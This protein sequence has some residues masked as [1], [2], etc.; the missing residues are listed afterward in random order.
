MRRAQLLSLLLTA[1]S[2]APALAQ[3]W[4]TEVQAGRIRSALDPASA[5]FESVMFGVRYDHI[6]S[7]V[8]IS[9]GVPTAADRP[10]WGALSGTH[11]LAYRRHGFVA[12]ADFAGSAFGMRGREQRT[13]QVGNGPLQPPQVVTTPGASGYAGMLQGLPLI[14]YEATRVQI[15]VR[16][17]IS[18]YSSEIGDVRRDRTVKLADVQLT[19]A[20]ASS[21]ML[22]PTIRHVIAED[23][24][25]TYAGALA[26][27]GAGP[28]SIWGSAGTWA[29]LDS[30]PAAW[31]GGANVRVRDRVTLT[32][33]ARRDPFDPVY[34]TPAQD[35]WSV[36]MVVKLGDLPE[37]RLPAVVDRGNAVIQ[38]PL[39]HASRV[40]RVAGDFNAWKPQPMQRAG[41]AWVYPVKL[42]PGVYN[43]AFVDDD[44]KWFVPPKHPGRK[45]DGMG[46]TVAVLVVR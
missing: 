13:Q 21:L 32:A 34:G 27:V 26:A 19:W 8:R 24:D 44:G 14:G 1:A 39:A 43:Y 33:S 4:S 25:F 10:F 15:H 36:G 35:A 18:H 7:Q 5:A 17:G 45:S 46:G 29:N 41:S 6:S 38:L 9:A 3:Q 11:R 22:M 31:A 2:A 12:G 40:P 30:E 28:V 16:G 23:G 37:R 20:P 42:T